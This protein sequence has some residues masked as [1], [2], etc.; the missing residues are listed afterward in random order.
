MFSREPMAKDQAAHFPGTTGMPGVRGHVVSIAI[1][2][3]I[4]FGSWLAASSFWL[5]TLLNAAEPEE[6]P[7]DPTQIRRVLISPERVPEILARVKEGILVQLPR[8]E[9][10][11]K[12]RRALL[13]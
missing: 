5:P 13:P 2:L 6:N 10:E 4:V 8:Q 9:F 1:S 12:V 7:L 3:A 11:E